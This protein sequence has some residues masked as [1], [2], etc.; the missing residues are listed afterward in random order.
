MHILSSNSVS[1]EEFRTLNDPILNEIAI[2]PLKIGGMISRNA[3]FTYI[4]WS[5]VA[6]LD[7]FLDRYSSY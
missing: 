1:N 4:L 6:K 2:P 7:L 3:L 5:R